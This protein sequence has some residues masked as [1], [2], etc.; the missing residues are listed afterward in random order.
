MLGSVLGTLVLS[1]A[2]FI[3]QFIIEARRKCLVN[4]PIVV[5]GDN[6]AVVKMMQEKAISNR[7]RHI[8]LRWHHMMDSIKAGLV[9]PHSIQGELNPSDCLTKALN[10]ARTKVMR[11]DML[12]LNLMNKM[13]GKT[14]PK[15][16]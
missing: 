2:L 11:D 5:H 16:L 8:A 3:M 14:V 10:G 13:K 15:H 9:E 7:A 6:A 12:G 4:G 1:F